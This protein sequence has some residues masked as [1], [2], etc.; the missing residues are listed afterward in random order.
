M[1]KTIKDICTVRTGYSFR[2]GV[3]NDP[4]GNVYV[5][6]MRDLTENYTELNKD[7]FKINLP[8]DENHHL[9]NEGDII[10]ISKGTNNRS[11][12][13][14]GDFKAI[15]A[16]T[17]FVVSILPE[18]KK[19]ISPN[20]LSWYF[21]SD[22]GQ[23][24]FKSHLKGTT[25]PNLHRGDLLNMSIQ[26]PNLKIQEAVA[27]IYNLN[28]REIKLEKELRKSKDIFIGQKLNELINK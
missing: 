8:A 12:V 27:E 19:L 18:H 11:L 28:L 6:Q 5:I 14:S 20:Y 22:L 2:Q 25:V 16:A 24:Y 26:I 3:K 10:L 13:F 17:F 9:L 1:Q 23:S 15:A 7:L 4:D 21:N